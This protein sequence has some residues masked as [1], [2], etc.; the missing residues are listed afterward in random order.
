MTWLLPSHDDSVV[1]V[2]V[3]KKQATPM[4][5]ET[6]HDTAA[7]PKTPLPLVHV[8]SE[9]V[10]ESEVVAPIPLHAREED[11]IPVPVGTL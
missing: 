3:R 7:D 2:F 9:L 8:P 1:P 5:P 10:S 4:P 6:Q 11:K